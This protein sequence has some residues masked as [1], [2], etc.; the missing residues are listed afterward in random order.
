MSTEPVTPGDEAPR[1]GFFNPELLLARV[2]LLA[3]ETGMG[4]L[5]SVAY[6]KMTAEGIRLLHSM[7]AVKL[8]REYPWLARYQET[9][10]L[11]VAQIIALIMMVVTMTSLFCGLKKWLTDDE[12]DNLDPERARVVVYA[13][14]ILFPGLDGALFYAAA[15]QMGWSE[16]LLSFPAILMTVL[17]IGLLIFVSYVSVSLHQ[18]IKKLREED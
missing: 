5:L 8:S 10:N 12:T 15:R 1:R 2:K 6:L 13:S 17:W 3:W 7:T 4:S 18:N 11:D 16:S 9:R 14:A